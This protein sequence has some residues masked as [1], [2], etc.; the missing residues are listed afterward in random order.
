MADAIRLVSIRRGYDPRDFALVLLGGA[1]P[2]HGGRLAAELSISRM[3]VP[4]LPGVLSALGLLVAK[5]EHDQAVTVAT[6]LASAT[7]EHLESTF[8]TLE[9]QVATRMRADNAPESETVTVRSADARYLGQAYTLEIPIARPLSR[10]SLVSFG[11]GF[12]AAH[13][14]VYGH[15]DLA[16]PIELVNVRV[17]QSWSFPPF[18][19]RPVTPSTARGQTSRQVYFEES[20]GYVAVPVLRRE[21]ID[22]GMTIGGPTII[23]QFDSTLVL[24]PRHHAHLEPTGNLIVS[25]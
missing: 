7:S 1:G 3:V 13:Q 18:D 5:I 9:G 10:D 16:A 6:R 4:A 22:V 15:A 19:F 24:Y 11:D 2:V 12:H 21:E 17:V 25:T 8:A 20:G 23:E 14:R